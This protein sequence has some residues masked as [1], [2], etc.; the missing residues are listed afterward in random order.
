[1]KPDC[2]DGP[3]LELTSDPCARGFTGIKN[4]TQQLHT[5]ED[6]KWIWYLAGKHI[7]S[8]KLIVI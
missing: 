5:T 3:G 7:Q 4:N 6:V 8:L 1:M 2:W